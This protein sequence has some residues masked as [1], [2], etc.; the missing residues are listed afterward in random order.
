MNFPH[1][2]VPILFRT[3]QELFFFFFLTSF[4]CYLENYSVKSKV[5]FFCKWILGCNTKMP[6]VGYI[7]HALFLL[8]VKHVS[9]VR[10][11]AV[12]I[13][14]SVFFF[15]ICELVV[16][17]FDFVFAFRKSARDVCPTFYVHAVASHS[18]NALTI[19]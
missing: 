14:F 1:L 5:E 11:T 10:H 9:F 7:L 19:I 13:V 6:Q 12:C 18:R 17:C 4:Q 2:L 3:A 8:C 16:V 15:V